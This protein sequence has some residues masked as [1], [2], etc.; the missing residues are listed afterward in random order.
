MKMSKEKELNNIWEN[1]SDQRK[2]K[3]QKHADELEKEYLNPTKIK[4]NRRDW[5]EV[6]NIARILYTNKRVR[7][8][9]K[10]GYPRAIIAEGNMS[11]IL[12]RLVNAGV[13]AK[14]IEEIKN[15]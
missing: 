15:A 14:R 10:S 3:I 11:S 12:L 8:Y 2:E 1:I 13:S 7:V 6:D 4:V 5:I 9:K